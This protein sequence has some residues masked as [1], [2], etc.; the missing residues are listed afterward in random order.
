MRY[1]KLIETASYIAKDKV[2]N[3]ELETHLN[4]P[5]GYIQK[6]TGIKERYYAKQESIESLAIQAVKKLIDKIE[7]KEKEGIG[8][9]IVATTSTDKLMPGI[10]NQIQK[11]CNLPE[12]IICLDVLAGCSGYINIFDIATM[13]M[14]T[15]RI[16]KA[17]IVGVDKLSTFINPDDFSTAIIFAD[18]AGAI[19]VAETKEEK[20]YVC[21]IQAK[22]KNN[23]ILTSK[24]DEKIYM[25]GKEIYKYAVKSTVQNIKE[26]LQQANESLENIKYIIPHQSN[27]RIMRAIATRL[28]IPQEKLYTNIEMIGNTFCASIPIAVDELYQK[29]ALEQ[30]DKVILLGY[31]GGLNTGS[32]L[33]EI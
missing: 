8:L 9:V 33:L 17:I 10:A 25:E 23:H 22:A 30:G 16:K 12:D 14:Q 4:L 7:E 20:K 24:T 1:I 3:H 19:L 27:M 18:G 15:G 21:H 13:Y 2:L 5:S 11:E 29:G 28:E 6:R 26:L 32:I 31:G